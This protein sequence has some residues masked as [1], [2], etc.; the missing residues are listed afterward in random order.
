MT[1]WQS[2]AMRGY[3][4]CPDCGDVRVVSSEAYPRNGN[5]HKPTPRYRWEVYRHGVGIGTGHGRAS[6]SEL[7]AWDTLAHKAKRDGT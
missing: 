1:T 3:L 5:V 6:A 2:K 4:T 7:I